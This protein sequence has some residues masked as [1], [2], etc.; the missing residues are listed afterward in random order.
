MHPTFLILMK[1]WLHVI[2]KVGVC[3]YVIFRFSCCWRR[4]LFFY[5]NV[6]WISWNHKKM[7]LKHLNQILST[8]KLIIIIKPGS[9][10]I[11]TSPSTLEDI[12]LLQMHLY[13]P[14]SSTENSWIVNWSRV[15]YWPKSYCAIEYFPSISLMI[16]ARFL[17]VTW[18]KEKIYK[19]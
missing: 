4:L 17:R 12:G 3:I 18:K 6:L 9:R 1:L 15:L 13:I 19:I 14:R 8:G 16:P 5:K 2:A 10:T 7:F 11:W